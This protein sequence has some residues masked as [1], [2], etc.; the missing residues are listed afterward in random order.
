[1]TNITISPLAEQLSAYLDSP[2]WQDARLTLQMRL[3]MES[4]QQICDECRNLLMSN[5]IGK[6]WMR[7][8]MT[9][10]RA[11]EKIM[12]RKPTQWDYEDF[13]YYI[14]VMKEVG[15]SIPDTSSATP[16]LNIER[17]K[18]PLNTPKAMKIWQIY[19]EE[20][21]IDQDFHSL[22]SRTETAFLVKYMAQLLELRNNY[23]SMFEELFEL[24]ELRQASGK[25][26][27]SGKVWQLKE[28]LEKILPL[29]E[30]DVVTK[31]KKR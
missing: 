6:M 25:A 13:C 1:M 31:K 22:R 8:Y 9:P 26:L 20:G 11:I 3:Q 7:Y 29:P 23:W 27:D 12:E 17:V 16:T 30:S 28:H 10:E 2:D 5:V 19:F 15:T 14:S 21:Y 4:P 18:A 24:K